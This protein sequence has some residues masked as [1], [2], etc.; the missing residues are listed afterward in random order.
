MRRGFLPLAAAAFWLLA[1]GDGWAHFGMLIPSDTMV[2]PGEEKTVTLTASFS[3]PMEMKGMDMER[4]AGFGV[5]AGGTAE[6]LRQELRETKLMGGRAWTLDYRIGRPGVYIFHLEPTP[7]W[8]PAEDCYI[9]HYTKAVIS[10]FGDEEGWD[11]L[12]GLKTEIQ[13]LSRPFGLYAGNVFQGVVLLNGQAVPNA[14]VEVEYY[15]QEGKAVAPTDYL[16]TQVVKADR[17]GVFTYAVPKSG[18]WG[19]AALNPSDRKLKR[20]GEDKDV[21]LGAVIWVY[22]HRWQE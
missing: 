18:W 10:A 7:Y 8:E 6:D 2:M 12:L 22:F 20:D 17:N 13:P 15:N 5:S 9:V 14:T 21:E 16:I 3:H 4:P 11:R 1:A 19:F